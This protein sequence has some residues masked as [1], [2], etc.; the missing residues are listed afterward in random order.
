MLIRLR[1][2]ETKIDLWTYKLDINIP[3]YFLNSTHNICLRKIFVELE[4]PH[5]VPRS[6]FWS[7]QTTAIDKTA[8]NPQQELCSFFGKNI[9]LPN[10]ES[11]YAVVFYEPVM[12]VDYKIQL[13]ALHTSEFIFTSQRPDESTEIVFVE[14]LLEITKH[15]WIQ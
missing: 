1:G 5:T 12:R 2:P 14:I 4:N 13:A 8:F 10:V 6:N 3:V 11:H 15:A 7:L 9:R